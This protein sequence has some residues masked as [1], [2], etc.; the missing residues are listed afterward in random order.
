MSYNNQ[1]LKQPEKIASSPDV[2]QTANDFTQLH[3]E[4][5][6]EFALKRLHDSNIYREEFIK[7]VIF[8]EYF[9]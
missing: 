2:I 1:F 3:L 4:D 7:E 5:N 9:Y 6:R 8:V